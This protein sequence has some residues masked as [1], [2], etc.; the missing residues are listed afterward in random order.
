MRRFQLSCLAMLFGM[1]AAT[2]SSE[3]PMEIYIDADYVVSVAAAQAIELGVRTALAEAGN[4]LAGEDVIVVPLDHRG[5]VKRSRLTMDRFVESKTALAV[6]GGLHSPPYLSNRDF[7]NENGILTLLPW[8]AAG[9]ITRAEPGQTNWIFRLSV[10]DYQ[11]GPYLVGHAEEHDDCH[12]TGLILL[13]SGWGRAN[14][15]TL[16]E[17]FQRLG[18]EPAAVHFFPTS[19]GEASAR[20]FAADVERSA[21][22]CAILLANWD[23]GAVVVNAL[24]ER[25]LDMRILSHWGILG[26]AFADA[27]PFEVRESLGLEVL[28]TCTLRREREG[29]AVLRR[30]LE[31]ARPDLRSIAEL[32]A[33]T[34]FVHGYDLTRL[35][36]AAVDQ[37]A[38]T[39]AWNEGIGAR[40]DAVRIAL[41]ELETPV[42]GILDTYERPFEPYRADRPYAHEALR[43]DHLCMARIRADG[44]LEDAN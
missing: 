23:N 37:A 31:H 29:N 30:A 6:V 16:T 5:N 9:P 24:Y 20:A 15:P 39:P 17:A 13:D 32:P 4:R 12:R 44:R 34:G 26:G 36:I 11:S 14:L 19:L 1:F 43:L 28:Q 35:L 8:S 3:Q 2:A 25:G 42:A 40:R 38:A 21:M 10:D 22:D 18:H 33:S 27:V 7:M 41:E